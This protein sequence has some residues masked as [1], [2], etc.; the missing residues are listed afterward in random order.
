MYALDSQ[1]FSFIVIPHFDGVHLTAVNSVFK[2]SV[3]K[4]VSSIL[5]QG[6]I[7]EV[8]PLDVNRG[9][10]SHYF[11]ISKKGQ[12]SATYIRYALAEF[13][14]LQGEIQNVKAESYSGSLL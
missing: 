8:P 2:A 4:K 5:L 6:A 1:C 3:L 12:R 14:S 9:L 13:L 10:F 7:E 11:L